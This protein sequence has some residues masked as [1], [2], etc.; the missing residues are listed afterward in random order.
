MLITSYKIDEVHFRLL[1]TNGFH[2]KAKNERFTAAGLRCRQNLKYEHV[3]SLF[4]RL[5]QNIAARSVPHVH[6]DHFS[7]FDRLNR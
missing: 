3:T 1:G 6:H 2:A 7:L 4:G 5:N